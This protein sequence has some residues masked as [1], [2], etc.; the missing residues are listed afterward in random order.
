[1]EEE[2]EQGGRTAGTPNVTRRWPYLFA[3]ISARFHRSGYGAASR[4]LHTKVLCRHLRYRTAGRVHNN[5]S[6]NTSRH[7]RRRCENRSCV[8]RN[9]GVPPMGSSRRATVRLS[10]VFRV[11]RAFRDSALT[12]RE[13]ERETHQV[14][15]SQAP[16]DI[17]DECEKN[18][19]SSVASATRARQ[20]RCTSLPEDDTNRHDMSWHSRPPRDDSPNIHMIGGRVLVQEEIP[21][22]S[23]R[24][25]RWPKEEVM[26]SRNQ[27]WFHS[28][29]ELLCVYYLVSQPCYPIVALAFFR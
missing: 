21:G 13:T 4:P 17:C 7:P 10:S 23:L 8:T 20:E 22:I 16:R 6:W 5:T 11:S 24:P 18:L 9:I 12:R 1:M 27:L 25:D 3:I 15:I 19:L 2:Y 26:T 14:R 28:V 29:R